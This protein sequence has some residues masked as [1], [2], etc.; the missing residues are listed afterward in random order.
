MCLEKKFSVTDISYFE[1]FI[2]LTAAAF[3]QGKMHI[4]NH[5]LVSNIF[6]KFKC[7]CS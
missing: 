7:L 4:I 2:D 1:G 5:G 3:G 6:P